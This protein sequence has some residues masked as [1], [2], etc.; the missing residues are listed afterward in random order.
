MKVI[1]PCGGKSSRF[2]DMRPK[3]MLTHPDGDLM[4]KKAIEQINVEPE[5]IIITILREHEEKYDIIRGLKENIGEK[6]NIVV[7]DEQTKNQPETVYLTLKKTG[8]NEGFL[9]KDSDNTSAIP[10]WREDKNYVCYSDIQEYEDINPGNKSY[11]KLNDQNIIIDIVEK[12]VISRF[13]NVGGYF[14][15]DP[16]KFMATFEKLNKKNNGSE[17][18][19]SHIIE[20]MILN[21]GELFFGKKINSYIDFGTP[22]QWNKYIRQFKTYFF[23]VDGVLFENGAQYFKPRWEDTKPL[24]ENLEVIKKLSENDKIQLFFITSRPEKYRAMLEKK[25]KNLGIKYS[26]LIMD[27]LHSKRIIVDDFSNTT[28]YPKCEAINILRDSEDLKKY[29]CN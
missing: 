9:I 5:D 13:F 21:Q 1:V 2:P 3:W 17:L 29:I 11:I 23:D 22:E 7:L 25:L 4:V 6:I 28:G 14:F 10:S 24:N 18:Y 16:Q 26:G 27:C 12:K 19:I 15:T 20:D 8:I